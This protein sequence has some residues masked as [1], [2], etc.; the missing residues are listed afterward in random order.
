MFFVFFK[1]KR[2]REE[3]RTEKNHLNRKKT[4]LAQL[5]ETKI[6]K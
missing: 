5:C 2:K 1:K 3:N 4:N 6:K